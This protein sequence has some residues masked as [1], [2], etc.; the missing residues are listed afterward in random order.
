MEMR[1][2]VAED[3]RADAY[4]NGASRLVDLGCGDGTWLDA[5]QATDSIGIDIAG[6]TEPP[7]GRS[8]K[9]ITA[10]LDD[11]IP[12]DDAWADGVRANQVIEHIR[13]PLR[14][15]TEVHRV[16][17]PN[18]VFVATTPNVRYARHLAR[19]VLRGDGPM[20][21]GEAERSAASWDD[22]HIHYFT[23]RDLEWLAAASRFSAYRTEALVELDGRLQPV[24]RVLNRLRGHA[25]VKGFL[26]GNLLLL[27][28]K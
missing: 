15:V 6:A 16:L 1:D 14:F 18:G 4:L 10:D 7:L 23:S 24:R 17:R 2:P 20:T 28:R 19:L 3:P 9:F 25:F 27:A 8:W 21:S 26:T 13:N 12:I 5:R 11:G 22:G